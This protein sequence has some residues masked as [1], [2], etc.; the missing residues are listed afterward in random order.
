MAAK[1]GFKIDKGW[2]RLE[3]GFDGRKFKGVSR[4]HLRVATQRNGAIAVSAVRRVVRAGGFEPRAALTIHIS[5]SGKRPLV[6]SATR[7]F[8]GLTAVVRSDTRVFVGFKLGNPA[9]G[10]A[11]A[12]HEGAIIKVTDKMREMFRILWLASMGTIDPSILTGRAA[13]LWERKSGGWLPLNAATQ[14]IVIPARPFIKKAFADTKLKARVKRNW[15][16]A[17]QKSLAEQAK[18]KK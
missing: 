2:P 18:K 12:V 15:E 8:Q 1:T 14:L 3:L 13:A 17:I 5:G 11:V 10:A 16:I 4:K 7:L 9:F 6:D